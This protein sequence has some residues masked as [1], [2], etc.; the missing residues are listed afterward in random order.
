MNKGELS[1]TEREGLIT[2]V[3]KPSKR[4]NMISSWRP[5]TLLHSTYNILSAIIANMLKRVLGSILYSDQTAF[6]K[7]M[8]IGE[9][10]EWCMMR[11]GK[12]IKVQ[13]KDFS[14]LSILNPRLT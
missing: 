5:I 11:Y 6:L 13:E 3:P 4:R 1:I 14:F 2:L 10:T 9:N 12:H 8:F 7:G